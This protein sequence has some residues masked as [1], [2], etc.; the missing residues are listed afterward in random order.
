MS[1]GAME[2]SRGGQVE[3]LLRHGWTQRIA[4]HALEPIPLPGRYDE[5]RMQIEAVRSRVTAIVR[6]RL[7]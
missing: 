3:P 4:T 2:R 1:R 6:G 7:D 5:A